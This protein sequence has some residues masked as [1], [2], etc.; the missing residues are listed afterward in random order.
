MNESVSFS[1]LVQHDQIKQEISK[2]N[3]LPYL[4]ELTSVLTGKSLVLLYEILW[5][6]TFFEE[7]AR[8]LRANADFLGKIE[9]IS[10]GDSDG[11][12]KRAVS[13]L[14]WTLLEGIK[15]IYDVER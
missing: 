14:V 4:L 12:L 5:S 3:I 6:L 13:G 9:A 11:A 1:G 2:H 15:Y 8:A 10:K 7:T